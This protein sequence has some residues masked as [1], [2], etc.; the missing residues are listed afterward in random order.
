MSWERA[1]RP[2]ALAVLVGLAVAWLVPSDLPKLIARG[3]HIL[4]GRYPEA[5]LVSLA[6]ATLVGLLLAGLLWARVR[7][8]ELLLRTALVV[9][10]SALT[11]AGV[12]IWMASGPVAKS[13]PRYVEESI[14][15]LVP[16]AP[17]DLAGTT[18]RRH[19]DLSLSLKRRDRPGPARSYPR[20]PEGLPDAR[21]SLSTDAEGFRNP[22]RPARA[23]VVV[24][25]D[26]FAEGSMVD[27]TDTWSA[28]V[29]ERAGLRVY[30]AAVSG[31][32]VR[33][34]LNN[35]AAFGM[36]LEPGLVVVALYE[37][38]DFKPDSG[39]HWRAPDPEEGAW[40][41]LVAG[42]ER[43]RLYAFK[44]SPLRFRLKRWLVQN[45]GPV[46]ADAPVPAS[47]GLDWMP[48]A[49]E[50]P[51]GVQHYAFEPKRLMRLYW[52]RARF[53]K[54][55]HWTTNRDLLAE[56]E[57]LARAGGARVLFVYV[58]SKPHV[59]M[60]LVRDRVS[61]DALR[62]FAGWGDDDLPPAEEFEPLLFERLETQEAVFLA[63]CREAGHA[64]VSLT[65]ALREAMAAGEPVYFTYDQHWTREGHERVAEILAPYLSGG[66][67]G[68]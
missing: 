23:D 25:G 39:R 18:R 21:V 3:E 49:L 27:D 34:Y 8:L 38:N 41:R 17:V 9:G 10:F 32:S 13:K 6:L 58:P 52:E 40:G 43:N 20:A 56:I 24:L 67:S 59:V 68:P 44:L 14:H 36:E 16:Q 54:A 42:F 31:A 55:R 12:S 30:N 1:A 47:P 29:A 35:L 46:N 7:P 51:A 19:P 53:E 63:W 66:G 62:E 65:P 60:P 5:R 28:L 45:L 57:E 37:G 48:V 22:E 33:Q 2:L 26:S 15:E 61:A 64:C 50:T 11:W 4:L